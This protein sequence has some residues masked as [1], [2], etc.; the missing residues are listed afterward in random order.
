MISVC[1]HGFRPLHLFF[2]EFPLVG[3]IL[4]GIGDQEP[5]LHFFCAVWLLFIEKLIRIRF[6]DRIKVYEPVVGKPLESFTVKRQFPVFLRKFF[7]RLCYDI[8]TVP[9]VVIES[10]VL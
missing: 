3:G 5:V 8:R 6:C 10:V 4:W 2:S 1:K 7:N 9:G